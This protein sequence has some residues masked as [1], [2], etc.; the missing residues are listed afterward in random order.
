M[1]FSLAAAVAL[2]AVQAHAGGYVTYWCTNSKCDNA[3]GVGP[4]YDCGN[5]LKLGD[6]DSKRKR[7]G[8]SGETLKYDKFWGPGGFYDCCHAKGKGACYDI[9]N[10]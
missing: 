1:K 4:T 3:P 5:K 2:L 7:W 8:H 6:Y 10:I 9:Q